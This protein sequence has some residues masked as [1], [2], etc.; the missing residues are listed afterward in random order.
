MIFN[1]QVF[2]SAIYR[3]FLQRIVV[4]FLR[5]LYAFKDTQQSLIRGQLL[6]QFFAGIFL[7]SHTDPG[8]IHIYGAD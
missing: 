4:R 1:S 2:Q 3:F 6:R 8:D 5:V 7:V